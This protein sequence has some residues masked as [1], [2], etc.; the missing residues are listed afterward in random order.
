MNLHQMRVTTRLWLFVGL[1]VAALVTVV[2]FSAWRATSVTA[3]AEKVLGAIATK[4]QAANRWLGLVDTN[5]TR[6]QAL[7]LG[8]DPAVETTFKPLIASTS[9]EIGQVQK[10]IEAMDL[11]EADRQLLA[12]IASERQAVLATLGQIREA[13]AAGNTAKAAELAT[14]RFNPDAVRYLASL[15]DFATLQDR[16]AEVLK[17]EIQAKRMV[18]VQIAAAGVLLIVGVLVGGTVW[19]GRSIQRPLAAAISAAERIAQGDLTVKIAVDRADEFGD[20]ARALQGMNASLAGI[21]GQVRQATDSIATASAEIA[22]GNVDLSGRTEQ[23]ASQLQQTASSMEQL[24]GTVRQTADSARSAN[25]LAASAAQ[26]AERGGSVVAEVVAT[27]EDINNSSRRIADIIGTIDGI[28]FQT[29]I[30][31]LNA[32]VEAARAGEQGRGFAVVASEV[33]SLAQ[34][35]AEAAKEIKALIGSSVDKVEAGT[36]LVADAGST[37][38]EIVASVQR[39]NHIIGEIS[40]AAGEQSGGLGQIN[41]AVS[42][43]DRM[44]QQNAAL[45]EQSTAAAESLKGQAQRLGSLVGGFRLQHP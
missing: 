12:R 3:L 16:Q 36:R 29:N 20:L 33:R 13:K 6:V 9:E 7:A 32:A 37:M 10:A 28:A 45:V 26:V 27:M 1:I 15:R 43:L 18:T 4:Q 41:T 11:S 19:L 25:T 35:S 17:A 22:T 42:D 34:R 31:A 23:T 21:I 24:N 44:T 2:G 40:A 39:V 38:N 30:L 5:T 14:Q 8:N